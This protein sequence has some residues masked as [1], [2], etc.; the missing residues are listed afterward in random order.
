M[1]HHPELIV[2]LTHHDHTVAEAPEIFEQC[3]NAKA[4]LWGFKES[5]LP[6]PQ[7]KKLFSRM[8]EFGKTVGL[9]VVSYDE[10]LC[11]DGARMAAECGCDMLLGTMF[12]DSVNDFC[13]EHHLKYMPFVGT[14]T[15]RPSVLEGSVEDMLAQAGVCVEKGAYGLDLLGYRYTGD[16][17]ELIR[18]FVS[19]TAAP[20]C[21]AGSINSW[22]RLEFIRRVNPHSF[23]IGGAFFEHRF[24]ASFEEQINLVCD[25]MASGCRP[26]CAEK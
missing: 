17:G 4:R 7:M 19:G 20:V 25:Y 5:G 18:R 6:L 24:G 8:K 16:A 3:K 12:F 26:D 22:E 14:V 13:L 10:A 23:T 15:Q 9:E 2:M 11:L 21:V 1:N